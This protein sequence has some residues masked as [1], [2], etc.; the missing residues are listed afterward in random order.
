MSL[1]IQATVRTTLAFWLEFEQPVSFG[2]LVEGMVEPSP[3]FVYGA[4][5][6]FDPFRIE[7][8][9][10]NLVVTTCGRGMKQ[11]NVMDQGVATFAPI[12]VD[13]PARDTTVLDHDTMFLD[14]PWKLTAIAGKSMSRIKFS[15][16]A[17]RQS[18]RIDPKLFSA[19]LT[20]GGQELLLAAAAHPG[21]TEQQVEVL[22]DCPWTWV[23]QELKRNAAV[24]DNLRAVL[25]GYFPASPMVIGRPFP[26]RAPLRRGAW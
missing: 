17:L 9:G 21:L 18:P 20:S 5:L 12:F 24:P 3:D 8:D 19:I 15:A 26:T 6:P 2:P 16:Q 23:L 25:L 22:M 7:A 14:L 1:L 10:K 13:I 11:V 4:E